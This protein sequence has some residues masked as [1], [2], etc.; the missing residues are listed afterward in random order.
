ML[1]GDKLPHRLQL[2]LHPI[3]W[4]VEDRPR[5]AIFRGFF[6][7]WRRDA[8][9]DWESLLEKIEA[10]AAVREHLARGQGC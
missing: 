1:A 5:E 10:H 4:A 3:N 9:A 2:V 7:E 8:E 6:A